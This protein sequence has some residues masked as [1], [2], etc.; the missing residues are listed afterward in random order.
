MTQRDPK[1]LKHHPAQPTTRAADTTDLQ[2]AIKSVGRI[3]EPLLLANDDQTVLNG[4]R[5]RTAAIALGMKGVPIKTLADVAPD[6]PGALDIIMSCG[7]QRELT[8]LETVAILKEYEAHGIDFRAACRRVKIK[9]G[10]AALLAMLAI[11]PEEVRLAVGRHDGGRENGLSL[12]AYRHMARLPADDQLAIL[13]D[14]KLKASQVKQWK[15]NRAKETQSALKPQGDDSGVEAT[16][17]LLAAQVL[18]KNLAIV[19]T[20]LTTNPNG[21]TADVREALRPAL[22]QMKEVMEE[23]R[24]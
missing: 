17:A 9:A 18:R 7:S 19:H 1:D 14:G 16:E 24:S 11:G 20:F 12:S 21:A 8:T 22:L 2:A 6:S 4:W 15:R 10:R 13:Q 5:R 23:V 3:V